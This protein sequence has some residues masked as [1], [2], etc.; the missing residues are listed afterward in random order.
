[1][2]SRYGL[3]AAGVLAALGLRFA[4]DPLLAYS[5]YLPFIL[6]I[7]VAAGAGGRGPGCAATALSTLAVA[8]FFVEPRHSLGLALFFV[9]GLL[10]ARLIGDLRAAHLS[11]LRATRLVDL[12]HDAIVT[13]DAGRHIVG[14]NRGAEEIYGWTEPE[15]LGR[16]IHDLLQTTGRIST[17]QVDEH[18]FREGRWE[19]ELN[20][21]A[22]DGRH[23]CVESRQVLLRGEKDQAARV[24]EINR[25]VTERNRAN[26]ESRASR[27]RLLLALKAGRSGTFDWDANSN[28][29]VWSDELLDLYG[30]KPGEFGGTSQD[31]LECLVPEDRETALAAIHKSLETGLFELEFRITRRDTGE[32]RWMYGRA[33]VLFDDAGR[34][35]QMIG[36]HIDITERKRT[37]EALRRR[38]A[39]LDSLLASAPLGFAYFDR[40]HRYI[41]V[42]EELCRVNGLPAEAHIG[43]TVSEVL[44][45]NAGGVDPIIEDVFI[46]G[47]AVE[48][49]ITGETPREPGVERHWLAGFYPVFRNRREVSSVGA[50]V[51]EVT[52]RRRMEQRLREALAEAEERQRLL[53]AMM[54]HVPLGIT[55]ADAPDVRIRRVSRFGQELLDKRS[56]ELTG[57]PA[58]DHLAKWQV[59]HAD[60]VTPAT[61]DELPLTR[62]TKYGEIVSGEEWMVCEKDGSKVPILCTAAPIRDKEGR[63]SGGVIGWQDITNLKRAE[64]ALRASEARL[65]RT[66]EFSLLMTLHV[67]LDGRWL[68]APPTFARFLGYDS[69]AELLGRPFRDFSHPDDFE[70]D[71]TQVERL[72]RGEIKSF[73]MEKRFIRK[74]GSV[75]WGYLNCSIVSDEAG[76]PVHLLTYVRDINA[77]KRA[78]E[79][80]RESE[81]RYSALFG[82]K[83]NGI[84][85]CKVVTDAH[86]KPVDYEIIEVNDAYEAIT[87]I[88][89]GDIEGK[90]AREVFPGIEDFSFDYIGNYGKIGLE[91]GELAFETFFEAIRQWLSIYV[92]S[93]KRGEFVAMFTD[94]TERKRAEE[95]LRESEER[96]SLAIEFTELGLFDF[97]PQTGK[98]LWSDFAKRHF[99]LPPGAE[100]D[101]DTFHRGLHP[102]DRERVTQAVQRALQPESGGRYAT[103][104]RTVGLEDGKERWLSAWGRALFDPDGRPTR[105]IGVTVDITDRK[106]LE[107]QLRRRAEEIQTVMDVA[108]VAI[109]VAEDA[110]CNR[111]TGN[112][113]ANEFFEAATGENVSANVTT[114]RRFFSNGREQTFD[115]LPM[116]VAAAQGVEV[117]NAELE[118]HLPSGGRA[119]IL[120]HASPLRDARGRV[121]GCVGTFVDITE[122]KS[123]EEALRESEQRYRALFESMREGFVVGEVICDAAGNPAD[124]RFLQVNEAIASMMR[125]PRDQIAGHTYRELFPNRDWED[126]VE[127]F[128]R[129][130]L[131]GKPARLEHYVSGTE[132]HYHATAYSPG[133][134]RFAAVLTDVS[135][136]AKAEERLRQAQKLES[137]G[138]LAG[139]VAHD[140]NNLL[141]VILGSASSALEERPSCEH[142]KAIV[143]AAERAAHLTKQLLAYAGKGQFVKKAIDLTE[144]VLQSKQLLAASVAKRVNLV[145]NLAHDLPA[146]EEDPSRVE[147][148]LMNLVI[149]AGEA[150]PPKTDGRIEIGTGTCEITPE[151]AGQQSRYEVA[152]GAYVWL[153]VR[154][155]GTGMDEVTLSRIFDPFFSTKFTGRGLGLAAVDGIVRSSKG[156]IEVRSFPG[157]GT[158][159]RVFLPA[160][161]SKRLGEGGAPAERLPRRSSSTVLVVDDEEM[162]RQLASMILRRHGYEVLEAAD[163]KH[164]LRILAGSPVLPSVVVLD[165]A[166]PV[167]GGDELLPVLA[168]EYPS[169]KI[170]ISSGYPEEETRRGFGGAS[171]AGFLQKPYTAATLTNKIDEIFR[172]QSG[173]LVRFTRLG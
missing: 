27:Q 118:V 31:W 19:G 9:T 166:M 28:V 78:E 114:A 23:L 2:V 123:A 140:F 151:T 105:L 168:K 52:E 121:R 164:A 39:E 84:S 71:W 10:I 169:L 86:G 128:G 50:F 44:P 15:V 111:I 129:V 59:Y 1:M 170:V 30:F 24:L 161:P 32:V 92:Y 58:E 101:H 158:T 116:Q 21:I 89:K 133:P 70:A 122:R 38:T 95:A 68:K 63:I 4:L 146:V 107:E 106:L 55:I 7:I 127:G 130:A 82:N 20:H 162:V 137:V 40:E 36:I 173:R 76:N 75:T 93:P 5:P 65:A 80:L 109:W 48:S 157:G 45:V 147:Q 66:Q 41:R 120:G 131:T 8:W 54:E 165:L 43:R 138:L 33:D 14:W 145:F 132:R 104:Y 13:T 119:Y 142:S 153:E 46:T 167:M 83:I 126:W 57:I 100:V 34:T 73:E 3:A 155:N 98:V 17:A 69:E 47:E 77:Q 81:R 91:G 97:Q 79:A 144:L 150:M 85:H 74:D 72:V 171:I 134:G 154:D 113:V 139:G 143:S 141:T 35:A 53:D 87:G 62:A 117:R 29:N 88:K 159:F 135:E 110:E 115:E 90:R 156:F 102:D 18:I 67:S 112:R 22:R 103:E 148:I 60:G 61:A 51:I 96:L 42:N 125:L 6:A 56:E 99:G 12:S 124:W 108:P 37:E 49:E 11:A 16:R 172:Q 94:I 26:Q 149:N 163:G 25:D 64:E 136:S 160:S 152:A